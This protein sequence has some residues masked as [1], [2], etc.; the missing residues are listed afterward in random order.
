M[1]A[2]M[3]KFDAEAREAIRRGVA[4]LAR[5]G[6]LRELPRLSEKTEQKLLKAIE[7]YRQMTGRFPLDAAADV[8]Q[9]MAEMLEGLPGV[10][11]VTPAGSL[12]RGIRFIGVICGSLRRPL[13]ERRGGEPTGRRHKSW[14]DPLA[15]PRCP[16]RRYRPATAPR[17]SPISAISPRRAGKAV[18]IRAIPSA[19]SSLRRPHPYRFQPSP[20]GETPTRGRL[21]TS[22][23]A[24]PGCR[25]S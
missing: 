21:A 6:K 17:C 11:K 13:S 16:R 15:A 24:R 22:R 19:C 2:K 1:A 5:E 14:P 4:K 7:S 18:R 25:A 3:I 10:D 23:P 9:K 8:A 12:R 20:C